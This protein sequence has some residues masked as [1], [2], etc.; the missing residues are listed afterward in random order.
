[1]EFQDSKFVEELFKAKGLPT[2]EDW[3]YA[4][5]FITFLKLFFDATL[6]VSN[7]SY[8]TSNDM[9]ND[10]YGIYIM[11]NTCRENDDQSL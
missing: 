9:T 1:M 11:I 6:K 2:N 8:V 3:K 5:Q 7:S 10:I 4:R